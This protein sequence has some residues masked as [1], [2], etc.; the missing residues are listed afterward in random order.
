LP[1]ILK[2]YGKLFVK[3]EEEEEGEKKEEEEEGEKK[4]EEE[5]EKEKGEE[6]KK[7]QLKV[8]ENLVV[9]VFFC[10]GF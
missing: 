10:G 2:R 9:D 6:K 3:E 5:K 8:L 4:E 1:V 7:I